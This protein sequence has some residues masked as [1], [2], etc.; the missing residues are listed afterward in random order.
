MVQGGDGA[1]TCAL[2]ISGVPRGGSADLG[3]NA[4]PT[5]LQGTMDEHPGEAATRP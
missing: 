5:L 2:I 1:A 3:Q 4:H